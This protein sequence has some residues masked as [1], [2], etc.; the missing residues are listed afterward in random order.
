MTIVPQ[1]SA[2]NNEFA[3][4]AILMVIQAHGGSAAS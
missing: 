2:C 3:I 4:P 1:S